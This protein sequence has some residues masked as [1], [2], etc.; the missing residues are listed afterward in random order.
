MKTKLIMILM[1][2]LGSALGAGVVHGMQ[3]LKLKQERREVDQRWKASIKP[4]VEWYCD[5]QRKVPIP[6]T[7]DFSSNSVQQ[8]AFW[9]AFAN[10]Y[11]RTDTNRPLVSRD[12]RPLISDTGFRQDD[13]NGS[14]IWTSTS[15]QPSRT[16]RLSKP[17]GEC[18]LIKSWLGSGP[19]MNMT[20]W[21]R[22]VS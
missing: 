6:G 18:P 2:V 11:V 8:F 20:R 4:S 17:R 16:R 12:E 13:P 19:T 1:L 5:S 21:L 3:T 9:S 15:G 7:I 14:R 10:C 22:S